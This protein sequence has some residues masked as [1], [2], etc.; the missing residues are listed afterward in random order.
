[1]RFTKKNS[2]PWK[3]ERLGQ[4]IGKTPGA[5]FNE[6]NMYGGRELGFTRFGNNF[7]PYTEYLKCAAFGESVD[8]DNENYIKIAASAWGIYCRHEN[9][10]YYP[11]ELASLANTEFVVKQPEFYYRVIL[12]DDYSFELFLSDTQLPGFKKTGGFNI[13]RHP[14]VVDT[15]SNNLMAGVCNS[16]LD[17]NSYKIAV[18]KSAANYT[19]DN[20]LNNLTLASELYNIEVLTATQMLFLV[21]YATLDVQEAIGDG[22]IHETHPSPNDRIDY[23]RDDPTKFY[24]ELK[25]T[26][27]TG[28]ST[29]EQPTSDSESKSGHWNYRWEKDIWGGPYKTFVDGIR[30]TPRDATGV[31]KMYKVLY[32]SFLG[33]QDRPTFKDYAYIGDFY[34]EDPSSSLTNYYNYP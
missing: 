12:L 8:V 23:V 11:K 26:F 4:A 17:S 7:C 32:N 28:R 31:Y 22:V 24:D 14:V 25:D 29:G 18:N 20:I 33:N 2:E 5:D 3:A 21:E 16:D 19:P 13:D 30:I 10:I 27:G 9:N 6:F 15:V 34:K 1:M